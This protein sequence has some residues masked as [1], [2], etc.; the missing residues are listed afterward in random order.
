MILD[1]PTASL[2]PNT[3]GMILD[4]VKAMAAD[5]EDAKTV[6]IVTH[7]QTVMQVADKVYKL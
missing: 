5:S 6:I 7:D 4:I 2:D 3:K 1:E